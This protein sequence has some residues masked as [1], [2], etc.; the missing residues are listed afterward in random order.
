MCIVHTLEK[1]V[2][3]VMNQNVYKIFL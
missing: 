3:A 2:D 1:F